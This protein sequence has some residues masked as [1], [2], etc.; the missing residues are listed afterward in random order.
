MK[1]F[2][3]VTERLRKAPLPLLPR[4]GECKLD[5]GCNSPK[6]AISGKGHKKILV[7]GEAPGS[8]EDQLGRPFTGPAGDVLKEALGRYGVDL[9]SDCWITNSIICRPPNNKLPQRSIDFCRPNLVK[10]VKEL[11]PEIIIPL[12][13]SAV[14]SLLGWLWKGDAGR[15]SRWVGWQIP[16]Q[17]PNAWIYPTYHPSYVL[18]ERNEKTGHKNEAL[19]LW[20]D[21]HIQAACNLKGRPRKELPDYEGQVRVV[22]GPE[23]AAALID[24]VNETGNPIAFDFETDRL[25]PDHPDSRIICCAISN[26]IITVAYPWVRETIEATKRLLAGDCPKIAYN[27]KFEYRWCLRHKLQVN[28][29]LWDGM[30]SAH[31]LDS[32][33]GTKGLEFQSFVLLGKSAYKDYSQWMKTSKGGNEKNKL[34]EVDLPGLLRYCGLDALLEWLVWTKQRRLFKDEAHV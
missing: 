6:M 33:P 28:N 13:A 31:A 29:W 17:K 15:I 25:K 16:C 26:G 1:G 18:R 27:N 32:R 11:N 24:R 21:R 5:K 34:H 3:T 19:E 7:V 10:A 30:L 8:R 12:G 14:Q 9:R 2:F 22:Q 20:F 4:C 23:E